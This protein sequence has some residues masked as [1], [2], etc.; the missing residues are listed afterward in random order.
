MP[1]S[2]CRVRENQL[3]RVFSASKIA[4]IF[5]PPAA[6][7]LRPPDPPSWGP[8]RIGGGHFCQ[9]LY[10]ILQ[11]LRWDK[12]HGRT[13]TVRRSTPTAPTHPRAHTCTAPRRPAP[14]TSRSHTAIR[15]VTGW[16]TRVELN[17]SKKRSSLLFIGRHS[18]V[19]Q[20]WVRVGLSH[21]WPAGPSATSA[22]ARRREVRPTECRE[23][24]RTTRESG[25]DTRPCP[26]TYIHMSVS[27]G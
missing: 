4:K 15:P 22:G 3:Y 9:V 2:G 7:G 21:D 24:L 27:S 14:H 17:I 1:A 5:S 12:R 20:P 23:V 19:V 26:Y 18:R 11:P 16:V 6:G 10:L 8:G 25:T 13:Y